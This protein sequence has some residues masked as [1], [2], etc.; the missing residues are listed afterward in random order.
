M[1]GSKRERSPGKWTLTVT[2]GTDYTGKKRRFNKTFHGTAAQAEKALAIFYAECLSGSNQQQ[3][4]LTITQMVRSY[5]DDRPTDSLKANTIE[6]YN[7]CL[8]VWIEPYIGNLLILFAAEFQKFI[9]LLIK[10]ITG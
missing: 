6:N 1:P 5:I 10:L 4:S 8:N 7:Q 2:L 9:F 3:S